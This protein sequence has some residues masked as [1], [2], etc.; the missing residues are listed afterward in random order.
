MHRHA[1]DWTSMGLADGFFSCAMDQ[2]GFGMAS[3]F[4]RMRSEEGCLGPGIAVGKSEVSAGQWQWWLKK[5]GQTHKGQWKW[6]C[7]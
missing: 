2:R 4:V 5:S 3:V 6:M 1:L 7:R